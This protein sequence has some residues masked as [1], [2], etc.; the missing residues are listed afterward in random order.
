MDSS[1]TS[2]TRQAIAAPPPPKPTGLPRLSRLPMPKSSIP[3]LRQKA[4]HTSSTPPLEKKYSCS[5]TRPTSTVVPKAR[6]PLS[7]ANLNNRPS[8]HAHKSS[9]ASDGVFKKP[10]ARPMGRPL[11]NQT[12][13]VSGSSAGRSTVDDEVASVQSSLWSASRSSSKQ[14]YRPGEESNGTSVSSPEQVPNTPQPR[15][16][17]PSL[18]ERTMETLAKVPA[19]PK[20]RR[21]SSFFTP[22]S[23][24]APPSRPGSS[25]GV[26]PRSQDSDKGSA[27]TF[28]PIPSVPK[29]RTMK[30]SSTTFHTPNKRSVSIAPHNLMRAQSPT[31]ASQLRSVDKPAPLTPTLRSPTKAPIR[32]SKTISGRVPQPRGALSGL[33]AAPKPAAPSTPAKAPAKTLKLK[34]MPKKEMLKENDPS[35]KASAASKSSASLREQIRAAKAARQSLAAKEA[36]LEPSHALPTPEFEINTHDDPFNQQPKGQISVLQQR[37][38]TARSDGRLNIAAMSLKEIPKEVLVMYDTAVINESGV[39]WN[40]VVDLTRF[41]AADNEIETISDEA[42]PDEDPNNFN[43]DDDSKGPQFGGLEYL[44][45]HGNVLFDVPRGLRM[46]TMLTTLN[47]SHNRLMNDALETIAQITSLRELKIADNLLTGEL[48]SIEALHNLEVLEVQSNKLCSLPD[49]VCEMVKLRILNVS[50]NQLTDLPMNSLSKLPLVELLASNNKL[51]GSLFTTP[52]TTLP[53]LQTLDVSINSLSAIYDGAAGPHLPSLRE[54]NIAYNQIAALPDISTWSSLTT[55]LAADNRIS[56]LPFGF[57]DFLFIRTADFTGNDFKRVDENVGLME[58]L[59]NFLVGNNPL[60]ER[61][62]LTMNTGDL[63]ESLKGKLGPVGFVL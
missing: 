26:R 31:K 3:N 52:A 17:R 35:P 20:L 61:K 16:S 21:K 63:K 36:A 1:P 40:E 13:Q 32:G 29:S 59:D 12:R 50:N 42:F 10:M 53:R 6:T 56:E 46:L 49:E 51:A 45:L 27:L 28:T 8:S 58:S 62:Y 25:L 39:A 54:F 43:Q 11:Q 7:T 18:S 37:I 19:S 60:R 41:V 38:N 9:I 48:T 47:L 22:D 5:T 2:P 57:L 44:D 24:M 15:K 33:F 14:E 55:I 4:Q 34:G 23:P 30:H